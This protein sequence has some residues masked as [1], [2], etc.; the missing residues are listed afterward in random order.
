MWEAIYHKV[1]NNNNNNNTKK[2]SQG[3][4]LNWCRKFSHCKKKIKKIGVCLLII[5]LEYNKGISH[6]F[7]RQVS[8]YSK[9]NFYLN[10][11]FIKSHV[12]HWQ[13]TKKGVSQ[14]AWKPKEVKT[15]VVT[16]C[17]QHS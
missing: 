5:I 4:A 10:L 9:L 11:N 13:A 16:V 7:K 12:F 2:K 3:E 8:I 14:I 1:N 15:N 17:V 6:V